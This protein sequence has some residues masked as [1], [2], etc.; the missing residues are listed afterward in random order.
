MPNK[1]NIFGYDGEEFSR[2]FNVLKK[3]MKLPFNKLIDDSSDVKMNLG[4][5]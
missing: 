4:F 3:V 1:L 5:I 2:V